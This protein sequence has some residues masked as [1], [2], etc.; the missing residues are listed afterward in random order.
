MA[1]NERPKLL[2]LPG[3]DGTGELFVWL[4]KRL[5]SF[6][7]V[8]NLYYPEDIPQNYESLTNWAKSRIGSQS[9]FLLG[10]SFGGPIAINLAAVVPDQIRGLI[11]VSSFAKSPVSPA[12]LKL[13][14]SVNFHLIPVFMKSFALLG[15]GIEKDVKEKFISIIRRCN[16][17]TIQRRIIAVANCN[18]SKAISVPVLLLYDK[19][20]ILGNPQSILKLC[21]EN[22]SVHRKVIESPHMLLQTNTKIASNEIIAFIEKYV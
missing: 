4:I 2:L 21:Q 9:I 22:K 14:A 6:F 18:L 3:M 7:D 20:D 8:E 5:E 16:S 13:A 19:H 15:I 17:K 10:E 11:L 1:L 12:I